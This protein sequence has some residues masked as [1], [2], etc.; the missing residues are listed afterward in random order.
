MDGPSDSLRWLATHL[1]FSFSVSTMQRL[2]RRVEPPAPPTCPAPQASRR[3]QFRGRWSIEIGQTRGCWRGD[4]RLQS[5][6]LLLTVQARLWCTS[7][8]LFQL[9]LRAL[10]VSLGEEEDVHACSPE[11]RAFFGVDLSSL[12]TMCLVVCA[13]GRTRRASLIFFGWFFVGALLSIQP[14]PWKRSN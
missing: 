9:L 11:Y 13:R 8:F 4:D 6:E 2:T 12:L 3:W 14:R 5:P 1:L 10:S 7:E